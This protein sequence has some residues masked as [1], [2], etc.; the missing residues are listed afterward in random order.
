[1]LINTLCSSLPLPSS[2]SLPVR[3]QS[4][5]VA[6]TFHPGGE[7]GWDY[8]TVDA[9]NH[10]LSVTRAAH[11]QAIDTRSGKLLA[12]IPGQARSH[13]YAADD[14]IRRRIDNGK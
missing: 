10:R 1:M 7:G 9:P 12:D 5:H 4:W 2:A 11:T 3:A 8:V 14:L 13:G 6:A